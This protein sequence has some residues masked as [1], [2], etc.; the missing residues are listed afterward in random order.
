MLEEIRN[1]ARKQVKFTGGARLNAKQAPTGDVRSIRFKERTLSGVGG[2]GCGL[3]HLLK[4]KIHMCANI[5]M[6]WKLKFLF[7]IPSVI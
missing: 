3:Y 4:Y 7:M 2:A 6:S 5:V 1:H